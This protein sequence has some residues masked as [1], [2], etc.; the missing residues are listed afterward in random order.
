MH[1]VSFRNQTW[2]TAKSV[3]IRLLDGSWLSR[4]DLV[5]LEHFRTLRTP[6][7]GLASPF[8]E[9]Q[10]ER[11]DPATKNKPAARRNDLL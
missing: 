4:Y 9:K 8:L 3:E 10:F 11:N 6:N 5:L 2:P 7:R 1:F